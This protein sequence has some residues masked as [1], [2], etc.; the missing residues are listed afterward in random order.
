MGDH[1][2][3]WPV[4]RAD[5]AAL[6]AG[7]TELHRSGDGRGLE[8]LWVK[9]RNA[10][11]VARAR[12][13]WRVPGETIAAAFEVARYA[14]GRLD[15]EATSTSSLFGTPE[16]GEIDWRLQ[17][18]AEIASAHDVCPARWFDVELRLT[19]AQRA[20]EGLA[21]VH[22]PMLVRA[23][24]DLFEPPVALQF[25][26]PVGDQGW[27]RGLRFAPEDDDREVAAEDLPNPTRDRVFG[28]NNARLGTPYGVVERLDGAVGLAWLVD[29]LVGPWTPSEGPG[30]CVDLR[31]APLL[32]VDVA[33]VLPVFRAGI[34]VDPDRAPHVL[35]APWEV[36]VGD[37]LRDAIDRVRAATPVKARPERLA[38]IPDTTASGWAADPRG[39][40]AQAFPAM[41]ARTLALLERARTAA[42]A[43]LLRRRRPE[44]HDH[45]RGA[46]DGEFVAQ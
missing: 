23:L 10:Y 43:V 8:A 39:A 41:H 4:G 33:T 40:I 45:P 17:R 7:L 22:T 42:E 37:D 20:H 16:R 2:D 19:L 36:L 18:G 28:A 24:L 46:P 32:D 26:G 21:P 29:A 13:R 27:L 38:V 11:D 5:L 14:W 6:R 9:L 3:A 35:H 44:P 30:P 25:Q 31:G 12:R 34:R 1:V 15:A